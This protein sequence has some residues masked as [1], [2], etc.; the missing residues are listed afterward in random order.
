MKKITRND[1]F[2]QVQALYDSTLQDTER[3][4]LPEYQRVY[5][6]TSTKLKGIYWE[7]QE[8]K[9]DDTLL[10]SDL[11]RYDKYYKVVNELQEKIYALGGYEK[12]VLED[13][14]IALYHENSRILGAEFG[15]PPL[16]DA[17]AVQAMNTIWCQDGML[18]SDRIWKH[19]AQLIN[20]VEQGMVNT[21][22][23]GA[24]SK[25]LAKSIQQAFGTS[26]YDA[27]R[28]ARTELAHIMNK[29]ALDQY[30]EAGVEHYKVLVADGPCPICEELAQKEWTIDELV[31]PAHPNCR[32]CTIGVI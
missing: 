28:L 17:K 3:Q 16:S 18:W 19:K 1:H 2:S 20:L 32:C 22:T 10:A 21:I 23:T 9:A 6:E 24:N 8:A 5:R 4:L 15:I 27:Q 13:E 26:W 31:I 11:Y 14:L 12:G 7:I 29:A 25:E 30:A